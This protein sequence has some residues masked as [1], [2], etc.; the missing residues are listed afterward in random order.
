MPDY[1]ALVYFHGTGPKAIT[2]HFAPYCYELKIT[3]IEDIRVL[4]ECWRLG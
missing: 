4:A 3:A 2:D 1:S